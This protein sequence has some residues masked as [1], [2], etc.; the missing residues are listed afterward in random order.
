M[1][2]SYITV[3]IVYRLLF[4]TTSV[5]KST[6]MYKLLNFVLVFAVVHASPSSTEN[7]SST[8]NNGIDKS[9]LKWVLQKFLG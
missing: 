7:R 3:V 9:K 1:W 4:N 6:D 2:L 5:L 8:V